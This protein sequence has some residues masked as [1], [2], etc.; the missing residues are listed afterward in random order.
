MALLQ[1]VRVIGSDYCFIVKLSLPAFEVCTENP[2]LYY[3]GARQVIAELQRGNVFLSDASSAL[4]SR[5]EVLAD[6]Y[7]KRR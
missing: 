7:A 4:A 6:A 5:L 1:E 3:A 2:S